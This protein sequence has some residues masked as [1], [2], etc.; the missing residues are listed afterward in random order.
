MNHLHPVVS[1]F[2]ELER[3]HQ[4]IKFE[5]VCFEQAA[6]VGGTWAYTDQV[7]RDEYGNSIH[8]SMYKNLK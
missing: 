1:L 5:T 6:K 4:H 7:G 8:S 2:R 3:N